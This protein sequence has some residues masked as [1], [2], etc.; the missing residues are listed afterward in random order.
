MYRLKA[1]DRAAQM[2]KTMRW[3]SECT[4][5]WREKWSTVRDERNRARE[6]GQALRHAYEEASAKVDA[7]QMEK[8]EVE[9]ELMKT[10]SA[11]HKLAVKN[12]LAQ[13]RSIEIPEVTVE[14][15]DE[16]CDVKPESFTKAVQTD[17]DHFSEPHEMSASTRSHLA[18]RS[19]LAQRERKQLEE[20]CAELQTQ[21]NAAKEMNTELEEV[22][23]A[24]M[25][26][27]AELKRCY[28]EN[29]VNAR[30]IDSNEL[31]E[32]RGELAD[33]LAEV[34]RLREE[35]RVLAQKQST[36]TGSD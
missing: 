12:S 2:E 32:V 5:C 34:E 25:E 1:R 31:S 3:W 24:M 10:K 4:A 16:G 11:L 18:S 29:L 36:S 30:T 21:L 8:R 13:N 17:D 9:L 35:N 19:P 14:R 6:E 27:I 7:V 26:E 22:K 23:S 20:K 33:A 28:N 15:T